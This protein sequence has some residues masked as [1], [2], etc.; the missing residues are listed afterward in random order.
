MWIISTDINYYPSIDKFENEEDAKKIF[1]ELKADV[2]DENYFGM[3]VFLSEVK[4]LYK[5]EEYD[6]E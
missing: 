6:V 4:E 3:C 2:D 1:E 5:N